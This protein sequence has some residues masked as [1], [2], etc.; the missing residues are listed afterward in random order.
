MNA[1]VRRYGEGTFMPEPAGEIRMVTFA[2]PRDGVVLMCELVHPPSQKGRKVNI[3]LTEDDRDDLMRL[4]KSEAI[5]AR[6]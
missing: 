3:Y 5:R 2:N 6:K 1:K 4:L